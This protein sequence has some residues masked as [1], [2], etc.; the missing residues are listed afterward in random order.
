[1]PSEASGVLTC[2]HPI[3]N[4]F[5]KTVQRLNKVNLEIALEQLKCGTTPQHCERP[6]AMQRWDSEI[7][8]VNYEAIAHKGRKVCL[9]K[10][11]E[12]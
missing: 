8:S 9:L 3:A 7:N 10:H 4:F 2:S 6:P 5:E 12:S 1:M 11:P